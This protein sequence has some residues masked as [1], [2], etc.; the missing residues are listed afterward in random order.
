MPTVVE[1]MP[2][3]QMPDSWFGL[4][5]P[6]ALP[7]PVLD[8]LNGSMVQALRAPEVRTRLEQMGNF[9]AGNSPEEFAAVIRKTSDAYTRIVQR[10]GIKPED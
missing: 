2:G 6:A 4:F 9:V 3:L 5:G 7:R 8:R 1:A 10:A